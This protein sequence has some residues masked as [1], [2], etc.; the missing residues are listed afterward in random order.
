MLITC[1]RSSDHTS[2]DKESVWGSDFTLLETQSSQSMRLRRDFRVAGDDFCYIR[3]A[4][5]VSNRIVAIAARK[6]NAG[7]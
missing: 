4:L 2:E 5:P 3:L 7:Q 1:V 6:K